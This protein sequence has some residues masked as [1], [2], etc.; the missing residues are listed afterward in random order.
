MDLA[1]Y[2]D[3]S[4]FFGRFG[5]VQICEKF[6]RNLGAVGT[7][8]VKAKVSEI[9]DFPLCVPQRFQWWPLSAFMALRE[10]VLRRFEGGEMFAA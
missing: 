1:P 7:H 5:W 10:M 6:V 4:N 8:V 2:Q 3:F 9:F